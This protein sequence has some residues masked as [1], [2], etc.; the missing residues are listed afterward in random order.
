MTLSSASTAA[1]ESSQSIMVVSADSIAISLMPAISLWAIGLLASNCTI[2]C[3]SLCLKTS[4]LGLAAS[5]LKPINEADSAKAVLLPL[6]SLMTSA[7]S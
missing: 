2:K 4:S 7:L 5:P 3:K 6:S 1:T